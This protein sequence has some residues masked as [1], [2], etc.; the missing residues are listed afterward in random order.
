MLNSCMQFQVPPRAP[1]GVY[2][3]LPGQTPTHSVDEL[4]AMRARLP[5][6]RESFI[7]NCKCAEGHYS[8]CPRAQPH[9]LERQLR[10]EGAIHGDQVRGWVEQSCDDVG[11]EFKKCLGGRW[12]IDLIYDDTRDF[13]WVRS[14]FVLHGLSAVLLCLHPVHRSSWEGP[15][16]LKFH[17]A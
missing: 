14:S 13:G 15:S 7:A 10:E 16:C 2:V 17:R 11:G 1:I 9:T 8:T 3:T 5:P 6:L 4:A 12:H